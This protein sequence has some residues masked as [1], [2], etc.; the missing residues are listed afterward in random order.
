M[1]DNEVHYS[2]VIMDAMASQI[3]GVSVVCSAVCPGVDQRKHQSCASLA[4][5]RESNGDRCIPRTKGQ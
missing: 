5:V 4:F 3:T 1:T 2:D